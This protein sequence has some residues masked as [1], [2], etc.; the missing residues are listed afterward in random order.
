[1]TLLPGAA[2]FRAQFRDVLI[3][4]SPEQ[5]GFYSYLTSVVVRQPPSLISCFFV[6]LWSFANA[7]WSRALLL[8]LL[9]TRAIVS[10]VALDCLC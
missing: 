6:P 2:D 5:R 8:A 3:K 9:F 10:P 4:Y 7:S 1:M